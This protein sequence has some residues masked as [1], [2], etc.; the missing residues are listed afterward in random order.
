MPSYSAMLQFQSS[1]FQGDAVL[2]DILNDDPNTGTKN[3]HAGSPNASVE[4]VQQALFDLHWPQGNNPPVTDASAFV[5]GVYGPATTQAVLRYKKHYDLHYPRDEPA[6]SG[7]VDG[8]AGPQTLARLDAHI[9][10]LDESGAA[11]EAKAQDLNAQGTTVVLDTAVG[12]V[13]LLGQPG[14]MRLAT[15]D[16]A[17]GEI[18]FKPGVGAHETHGNIDIEYQRQGG[19]FGSFGFPTSDEH[20]DGAQVR[21]SDFEHGALRCEIQ[22]GVVSIVGTPPPPPEVRF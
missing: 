22:T 14:V 16:G 11:I 7:L 4:K 9:A 15:I 10:L 8:L 2:E 21:R 5:I 13:P 12:N 20:D 1:R 17:D 18:S 3:L 6:G 19:Q